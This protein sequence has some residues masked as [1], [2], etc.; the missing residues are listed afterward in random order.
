VERY[1]DF[2][3]P[4]HVLLSVRAHHESDVLA[5]LRET[6]RIA[7]APNLRGMRVVIKPNL[8]DFVGVYPAF[9]NP[10]MVER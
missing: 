7:Q 6:W 1:R 10:R 9:T 5:V 2:L 4:T 3:R 8:V